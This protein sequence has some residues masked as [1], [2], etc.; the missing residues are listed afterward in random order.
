MDEPTSNDAREFELFKMAVDSVKHITTLTTGTIV[1]L[2]TF[3]ERIP[4]P[5]AHK[6]DLAL[7]IVSMLLCLIV[8][9]IFLWGSTLA[10]FGPSKAWTTRSGKEPSLKAEVLLIYVFFCM[11][12]L[13]LG[14]F[15][16]Y[17]I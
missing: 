10:R 15:A 13:F 17:N 7:A 3:A 8:S 16:L 1:L 12:V 14:S 9:F 5:I 2:A 6:V 11:G 4:R